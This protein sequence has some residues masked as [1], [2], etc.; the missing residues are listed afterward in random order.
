MQVVRL[1]NTAVIL[2]EAKDDKTRLTSR[3]RVRLLVDLLQPLDARVSVDLGGGYRGMPQQLLDRPEVGSSVQQV[4][5]KG[6]PQRVHT[7]ARLFIDFVK[8]RTDE[9]SIAPDTRHDGDSQVHETAIDPVMDMITTC[10]V[11]YFVVLNDVD[12][13]WKL[14]KTAAQ[15]WIPYPMKSRSRACEKARPSRQRRRSPE[16]R[17]LLSLWLS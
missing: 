8:E 13:R 6:V 9:D 10:G 16:S 12:P 3:P 14:T 2:S 17:R 1:T 15:L 4:G 7:Q 5:R 11:P